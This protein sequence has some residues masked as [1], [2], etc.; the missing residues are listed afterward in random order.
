MKLLIGGKS[1]EGDSHNGA[2]LL[3]GF[4]DL[5]A[6]DEYDGRVVVSAA[7]TSELI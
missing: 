3:V 2:S 5:Q 6:F 1:A 4:S 7:A